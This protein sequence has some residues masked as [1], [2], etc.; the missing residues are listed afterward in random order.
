M[1]NPRSLQFLFLFGVV[2]LASLYFFPLWKITL[3]APQYPNGVEMH[4]H[5]DKI[6]GTEPGTLQNINILNHYIGM[7]PIEPD[8]IPEL[9]ILPVVIISFLITGILIA[10]SNNKYLFA[11]WACMLILSLIHI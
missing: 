4:I 11:F 6:G 9:K 7:K 10:I 5:I 2:L 8:S 1:N 3:L